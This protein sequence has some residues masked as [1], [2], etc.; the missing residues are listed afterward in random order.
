MSKLTLGFLVS[1]AVL[2]S[3]CEARSVNINVLELLVVVDNPARDQWINLAN[4]ESSFRQELF[5]TF[6]EVNEVFK[7]LS[8]YGLDLE[9]R[10]KEV[11]TP[12][13]NSLSLSST[14]VVDSSDALNKATDW[15]LGI[16]SEYDHAVILT[17]NKLQANGN[18][19]SGTTMMQATCYKESFSIVKANYD[20]NTA[21]T[22]VKLLAQSMDV[23]HDGQGRASECTAAEGYIMTSFGSVS[24]SEYRWSFSSCSAEQ[25]KTYIRFR[26]CLTM[27]SATELTGYKR[28]GQVV[29]A[30]ET[31]RR[32]TG[33][34]VVSG[35]EDRMCSELYCLDK[36]VGTM[37][38]MMIV[39]P[40]EG[41]ECEPGK[42]CLKGTCQPEV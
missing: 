31:C 3:L 25:I 41:L 24:D 13:E 36:T 34:T 33:K 22:I 6:V 10:V 39:D 18:P 1:L 7:T 12:D 28:F 42:M 9:I 11:L 15:L 4:G 38:Y 40:P 8:S 26:G 23:D 35:Y 19:I 16:D 20:Y 32:A 37:T 27:T 2:A 5:S 17:G 29:G 14:G 21:S 30:A